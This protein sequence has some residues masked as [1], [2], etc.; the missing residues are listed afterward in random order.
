M[1][2]DYA[3]LEP[4]QEI[5]RHSYQVD[6][7]MVSDYVTAVQDETPALMNETGEQLVPA[8]GCGSP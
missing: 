4:G 6:E 3:E 2:S 5:S 1:L 8:M 7:R